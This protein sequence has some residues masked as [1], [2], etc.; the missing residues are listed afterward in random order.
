M[1]QLAKQLVRMKGT[2]FIFIFENL[3]EYKHLALWHQRSLSLF[4]LQPCE[5]VQRNLSLVTFVERLGSEGENC[6]L[7]L[8]FLPSALPGGGG[9]RSEH[10]AAAMAAE[11][12]APSGDGDG[13]F[14][15][16]E[17]VSEE[18]A[19]LDEAALLDRLV[20][21][22]STPFA[23]SSSARRAGGEDERAVET[24]V[25]E[26][27]VAAWAERYT[28]PHGKAG[29]RVEEVARM[30][31]RN[32]LNDPTWIAQIAGDGRSKKSSS[33]RDILP[34][35]QCVRLLVRDERYL[36]LF[37]GWTSAEASAGAPCDTT[38]NCVGSIARI[39]N[40]CADKMTQN[41]PISAGDNQHSTGRGHIKSSSAVGGT[42]ST[43]NNGNGVGN[44]SNGNIARYDN[45]EH[46]ELLVQCVSIVKRI[47]SFC[48]A[49]NNGRRTAD[50]PNPVT[51]LIR[52]NVHLTLSQLITV[53]SVKHDYT[54][55]LP[56]VLLSLL[57]I[58]KNPAVVSVPVSGVSE[59]RGDGIDED[60]TLG[61]LQNDQHNDSSS[62]T[63]DGSHVAHNCLEHVCRCCT[64]SNV[65]DTLIRI[66]ETGATHGHG[67]RNHFYLKHVVAQ[68]LSALGSGNHGRS[69]AISMSDDDESTSS[70]HDARLEM[71]ECGIVATIV[72]LI[73]QLPTSA[74]EPA[75]A[76]ERG[77]ADREMKSLLLSLLSLLGCIAVGV[78]EAG[79]MEI[80]MAGAVPALLSLLRPRVLKDG[81]RG[82]YCSSIVCSIMSLFAQLATDDSCA[83]FIRQNNGVY[84]LSRMLLAD[85]EASAGGGTT[86]S[87]SDATQERTSY[88]TTPAT[89]DANNKSNTAGYK[90][91]ASLPLALVY[92]YILRA[93][94]FLF[95]VERNRKV[96]KKLFPLELFLLFIDVGHYN[97]NVSDY[98]RLADVIVNARMAREEKTMVAPEADVGGAAAS[99]PRRS[100]ATGGGDGQSTSAIE[101]SSSS[102]GGD[103]VYDRMVVSIGE[104]DLSGNAGS[105]T[106]DA[107]AGI[108]SWINSDATD[109]NSGAMRVNGYWMHEVIGRG[110]FGCV[111]Q[112]KKDGGDTQYA[113][114]EINLE[115]LQQQR[116][117][118]I[119]FG[120]SGT[121]Q[122]REN[123]ALPMMDDAHDTQDELVTTALSKEVSILR[124]IS[125]PN[126]VQYYDS[127]VF[128]CS[129]YIVM[130][131]VEGVTLL[132]YINS[133]ANNGNTK[134]H[135]RHGQ[136]AGLSGQH[137]DSDVNSAGQHGNGDNSTAQGGAHTVDGGAMSAPTSS[138]PIKATSN[139]NMTNA[140]IWS[141]FTQL[142]SALRFLHVKMNVVHRD[143]TPSNIMVMNGAYGNT[144]AKRIKLT[145]FGLST[146]TSPQNR[147]IGA[148]TTS[149]TTSAIGSGSTNF[150]RSVVGTI[151]YSCPEMITSN[152]YT[153]KADVWSAGCVLYHM[154]MRKPPFKGANPFSTAALIV[155]GEYAP[156]PTSD[157]CDTELKALVARL[158][159]KDPDVRP[160]IS[161]VCALMSDRIFSEMDR[162]QRDQ[163][164]VSEQLLIE[165][166]RRMR[167]SSNAFKQ[168]EAF[169][170]LLMTRD[171][172]GG[173]GDSSGANGKTNAGADSSSASTSS[174]FSVS[175]SQH[176]LRRIA[177]PMTQVLGLMHK[178]MFVSTLPAHSGP[179]GVAVQKPSAAT[180]K[181]G[182]TM[183]SEHLKRRAVDTYVSRHL[184]SAQ[185]R[186]GSIKHEVVKLLEGG[187]DFIPVD[188]SSRAAIM[189]NLSVPNRITYE[190]MKEYIEDIITGH[191]YYSR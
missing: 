140:T 39:M 67:G 137:I 143:I 85:Y 139:I 40:A 46:A 159:A 180:E 82:P 150:L 66:L 123:G 69:V 142:V 76:T 164:R 93:L 19:L 128:G 23:E 52:N 165:R 121:A 157:V 68:L 176:K 130:E 115:S 186:G 59:R 129:L 146:S 41:V 87:S 64:R 122:R 103:N 32:R 86:A 12:A 98:T 83:Y 108:A 78:G 105:T 191:G 132:E 2:P 6:P 81:T 14:H 124:S 51:L 37:I 75:A 8:R 112:A 154:M 7:R 174:S 62:Q 117:S 74:S 133:S 125:H 16:E 110:A 179:V 151:E 114:K 155:D 45:E 161:D 96:F 134:G 28:F 156:I 175:I 135:R 99:A 34:V 84:L 190:A 30:I 145:D 92:C 147:V 167:E 102:S 182:D 148:T 185:Y 163:D 177:D 35:M 53:H 106:R 72:K 47:S 44:A 58:A 73:V 33:C 131:L 80:R 136:R 3:E 162:M 1:E 38:Q 43:T 178:L 189:G 170:R 15:E 21:S 181:N 149:P 88:T 13:A 101:A 138:T 17:E 111:Y 25:I 120:D 90:S 97:N 42:S 104:L 56:S 65:I 109:P 172:G 152:C 188:F 94:R 71:L 10:Q 57:F 9:K 77:L 107:D 4:F 79:V 70:S 60:D 144:V 50:T 27:L 173:V 126:I 22:L 18:P 153:N 127:F 55:V 116:S 171:G 5:F 168:Q 54:T 91:S 141:I 36:Q 95:S 48:L 20:S 166:D 31:L 119:G 183:M 187:Q 113:V 169:R 24:E 11:L 29:A 158:L 118:E 26:R 89:F 160:S 100:A 63:A 184:F 61:A 49:A